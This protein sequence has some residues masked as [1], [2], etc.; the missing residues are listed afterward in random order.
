MLVKD[1][2][3]YWKQK[4]TKNLTLVTGR[5]EDIMM[6]N[7]M[8]PFGRAIILRYIIKNISDVSERVILDEVKNRLKLLTWSKA[9][10]PL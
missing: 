8:S 9:D 6:A 4:Q 2:L 7:F 10:C 3:F 5:A 1:F